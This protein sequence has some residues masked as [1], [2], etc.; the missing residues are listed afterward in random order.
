M[1]LYAT[2]GIV[3]SCKIIEHTFYKQCVVLYIVNINNN[4]HRRYVCYS[5]IKVKQS[6]ADNQ[7][8]NMLYQIYWNC[9]NYGLFSEM[10]STTVIR[11]YT[12]N[13]STVLSLLC[14]C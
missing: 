5:N 3:C 14:M 11:A 1:R 10:P 2:Y 4:I 12:C 8:Y 7:L 9:I 13:T 6:E